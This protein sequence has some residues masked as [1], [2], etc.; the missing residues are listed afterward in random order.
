MPCTRAKPL[1]IGLHADIPL[2]T[3]LQSYFRM[4]GTLP[5]SY[6]L[7]AKRVT[8][9]NSSYFAWP[10]N[11][12]I[13][14]NVSTTPYAHWGW[15]YP[16]LTGSPSYDCVYASEPLAYDIYLGGSSRDD[17]TNSLNFLTNEA[18]KAGWNLGLCTLRYYFICEAPSSV[19]PCFPPP[20]PPTPPPS[21]PSP[22]SPPMPPTCEQLE[23]HLPAWQ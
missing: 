7:S 19:F 12:T 20:S 21:P 8:A 15:Y 5:R 17:T 10:G 2:L 9:G 6:W 18:N 4:R 23:A 1:A 16:F 22:P 14:S 13:A 3:L 11:V